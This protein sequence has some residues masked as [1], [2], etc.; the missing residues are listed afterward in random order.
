MK[1]ISAKLKESKKEID[2]IYINC[3]CMLGDEEGHILLGVNKVHKAVLLKP[4]KAG[5]YKKVDEMDFK[6]TSLGYPMK[7]CQIQSVN[8]CDEIS[9]R[10]YKRKDY[11]LRIE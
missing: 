10:L 9:H 3:I 8:E 11:D 6:F 5:C 2:E 7:I 4:T 1:E